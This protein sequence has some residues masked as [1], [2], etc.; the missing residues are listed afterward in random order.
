MRRSMKAA[1]LAVTVLVPAACAPNPIIARDP[2][3]APGPDQAY[4]CRSRPMVLNLY[5][6]GCER[7][8][9]E[10]EAVVRSKG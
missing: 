4:R 8:V 9:P 1:L 6:T 10:Q 2:I 7:V 5:D 3:P